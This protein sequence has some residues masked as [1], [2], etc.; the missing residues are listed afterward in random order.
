MMASKAR[1]VD[2]VAHEEYRRKMTGLW[3]YFYRDVF[4]LKDYE[5]RVR[6]RLDR[7][8]GVRGVQR[9]SEF[10]DF[11]GKIVLDSGCGCGE[12]VLE[13]ILAGANCI[14]VEPNDTFLDCA[15]LLL[16][17]Y[18]V[19]PTKHL[20]KS[21]GEIMPFGGETF[22]LIISNSV[23][24]HAKDP[25]A[26]IHE[27]VRVTNFGG[28]VWLKCPN[29]LYP[30]ERHYKRYYLPFLPVAVT[31]LYFDLITGNKT[32]FFRTFN[33]VNPYFV[34]KE[35]DK[36]NDVNY[37]NL[38]KNDR[39]GLFGRVLDKI[40]ISPHVEFLIEKKQNQLKKRK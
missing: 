23:I 24:E 40:H 36:H 15:N 37:I 7:G 29:Y 21:S 6:N 12:F 18:G 38:S 10:F 11:D 28:I 14:G 34:M 30:F 32:N 31:Q 22:D 27:M 5:R 1:I 39:I 17:S 3:T 4:R 35:L 8:F 20:V 33:R 13:S 9:I 26:L 19:D 16:T 25:A 2:Q